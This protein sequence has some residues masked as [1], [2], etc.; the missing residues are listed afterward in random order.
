MAARRVLG[1]HP[2]PRYCVTALPSSALLLY[3][4]ALLLY[5]YYCRGYRSLLYSALLCFTLLCFTAAL[6]HTASCYCRR[7]R[8]LPYSAL[9]LYCFTLLLYC[10]ARFTPL[11]CCFTVLLYSALPLHSCTCRPL[12]TTAADTGRKTN[13]GVGFALLYSA[14]L[15]F[16]LLVYEA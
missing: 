2:P 14:L 7:Y 13:K 6:V 10:C 9:L 1:S 4:T 5:C 8:S 11:R 3:F 16:T 12:P 15:C